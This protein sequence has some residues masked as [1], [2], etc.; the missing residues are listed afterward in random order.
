MRLASECAHW[1][2]QIALPRVEVW[3]GERAGGVFALGL[4]SNCDVGLQLHSTG[5]T[6]LPSQLSSLHV[7]AHGTCQPL[8]SREPTP[9]VHTCLDLLR[10]LILWSRPA[11]APAGPGVSVL[12]S[13]I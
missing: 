2:K 1:E 3:I 8:Q 13:R 7:A 5:V 10:V 9:H 6:P 4:F 12:H 11:G